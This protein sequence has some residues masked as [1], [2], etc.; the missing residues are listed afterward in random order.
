MGNFFTEKKPDWVPPVNGKTSPNGQNPTNGA[1]PGAEQKS[2]NVS[3]A[4]IENNVKSAADFFAAPAEEYTERAG[5]EQRAA[6]QAAQQ[7]AQDQPDP[8]DSPNAQRGEDPNQGYYDRSFWQESAGLAID[9][10]DL[11]MARS[12]TYLEDR[13][14]PL[15]HVATPNDKQTMRIAAAKVAAKRN[16]KMTAEQYLLL[17]VAMVYVLPLA[18]ALFK[19][20]TSTRHKYKAAKQREKKQESEAKPYTTS[21]STVSDADVIEVVVE[22]ALKVCA[23]DGRQFKPGTGFP[24]NRQSETYDQFCCR[25]CWTSYTNK[26]NPKKAKTV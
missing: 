17:I 9:F 14:P 7:A 3:N 5:A 12:I 23:W 15:Q 13:N 19:Y 10:F 4:D 6:E 11:A 24:S 18:G 21:N 20:V 26:A 22:E 1:A 2:A 25:S 16:F 8:T